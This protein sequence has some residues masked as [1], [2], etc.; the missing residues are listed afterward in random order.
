MREG[1]SVRRRDDLIVSVKQR[2]IDAVKA[3][4][5]EAAVKYIEDLYNGFKPLH[6]R[7]CEWLQLLMAYIGE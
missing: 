5:T 1:A 6:N 2:A 4:D 3:G 7:Y